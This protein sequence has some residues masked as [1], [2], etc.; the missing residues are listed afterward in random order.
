MTACRAASSR[1]CAASATAR[2]T[3]H[4]RSLPA[5]TPKSPSVKGIIAGEQYSTVF[6]DTR[7]LAKVTANLVDAVL[8]GGKPRSTTTKTYNNGVKVVPSYL[9]DAGLGRQVQL[10]GDRGRLRL[11]QGRRAAV[12]DSGHGLDR[13]PRRF[14]RRG[15]RPVARHWLRRRCDYLG[16]ATG[17]SDREHDD[18]ILEMRGITKTFPGVKALQDVNLNVRAGEIHAVVRRKRRRQVDAD[19][20]ASR[21]SIPSAPIR[22]IDP[23]PRQGMPLHRHPRQRAAAASS[24]STRNSPWC[25]CCRSPRTSSSATSRPASA[26]STGTCR[27]AAPP[28]CC[29]RSGLNEDPDTLI[30]N[31]GVG[32]QQLVEI[33]KALA[34]EVKLLI[35]D[36]PTAILVGKGQRRAAQ[37]SPRIQASRASPR[38]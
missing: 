20:G 27:V 17:S 16:H 30:T 9:L 24:S 14:A 13:F 25:R 29:A 37:P 35:L 6:K 22:A 19:E 11:H 31:I 32:K 3:S 36:E 18:T 4:G 2:P 10:R 34:K 38:S 21:A 12:S 7:E 1:R 33:A 5:R 26:S 8:S 15:N 28:S 23:L